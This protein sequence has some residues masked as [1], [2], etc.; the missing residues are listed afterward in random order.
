MIGSIDDSSLSSLRKTVYWVFFITLFLEISGKDAIS[1]VSKKLLGDDRAIATES[2]YFI[3]FMISLFC[4]LRI[5]ILCYTN[6][7]SAI[8]QYK[9]V[10][11]EINNNYK[12]AMEDHSRLEDNVAL[13]KAMPKIELDDA[14]IQSIRSNIEFILEQLQEFPKERAGRNDKIGRSGA[15]MVKQPMAQVEAFQQQI[16]I[17]I[18]E[19]EKYI[20]YNQK[21]IQQSGHIK[22]V[23]DLV[24]H[25][26]KENMTIN[27]TRRSIFRLASNFNDF[28]IPYVFPILLSGYSIIVNYLKVFN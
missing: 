7:H 19:K 28:I 6:K 4:G 22:S 23:L 5:A 26:I 9:K 25:S 10:Y 11:E 2:I 12:K 15:E 24:K 21:L 16:A 3:L 17:L 20:N 1:I 13:I 18:E 27:K 8:N 14:K